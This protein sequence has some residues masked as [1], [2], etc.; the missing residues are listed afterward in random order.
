MG[1]NICEILLHAPRWSNKNS[2]K[3]QHLAWLDM[4]WRNWEIAFE[5]INSEW[6]VTKSLDFHLGFLA[7]SSCLL[8]LLAWFV[9]IDVGWWEIFKMFIIILQLLHLWGKVHSECKRRW[10]GR[11]SVRWGRYV[12]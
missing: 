4:A 3:L 7:Q 12:G 10:V 9:G 5:N 8:L 11:G 1:W 6:F 2:K